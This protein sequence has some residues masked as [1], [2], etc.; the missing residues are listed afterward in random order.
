[1]PVATN[2]PGAAVYVNGMLAGPNVA[3]TQALAEAIGIPV[4]ASGG[5]SS[6]E[7]LRA[8]KQITRLDGVISGRAL[9]DGRI[10]LAQAVA[11]LKDPTP[12]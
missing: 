1:M 11:L 3:A 6:L 9:Y 5:V 10:D 2:P 12:C 4:I 8:L 7:D